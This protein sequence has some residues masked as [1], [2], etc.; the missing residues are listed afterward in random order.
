LHATQPDIVYTHNLADKHDTHVAVALRLIEACRSLP[1]A[2]RPKR[3]LGCEVW[4]DL[5]WLCGGDQLRLPVQ[6]Q[7][8]LIA[9]LVGAHESQLAGGKRYDLAVLGRQR[10]HATFSESHLPN[11]AK[12][13]AFAMDLSPLIQD[14]AGSPAD[15]ARELLDHFQRD[16]LERIQR[17]APRS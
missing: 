11:D 10:A 3:V 5:D 6:D 12:G 9:A 2:A 8:A 7:D 13:L 1:A 14:P 17:L 16:V 15:Y 4:R